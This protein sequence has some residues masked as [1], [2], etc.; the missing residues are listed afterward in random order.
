[1]I[2]NENDDEY[3]R[4]INNQEKKFL[5]SL[6]LD[7]QPVYLHG[8]TFRMFFAFFKYNLMTLLIRINS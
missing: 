3:N 6:K 1:M 5:L 8:Y 2:A 4:A 7:D